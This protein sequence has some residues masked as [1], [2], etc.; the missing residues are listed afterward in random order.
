M[1]YLHM[2]RGSRVTK[3]LY[4]SR[5]QGKITPG[6]LDDTAREAYSCGL[7]AY[8]ALAFNK[9]LDAP[10][11]A[12]VHSDQDPDGEYRPEDIPEHFGVEIDGEIVDI[13]GAQSFEFW[14][15]ANDGYAVHITA[16][17]VRAWQRNHENNKWSRSK[18]WE[19]NLL[20]AETFVPALMAGLE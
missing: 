8:L 19:E 18:S 4:V 10:I 13:N 6:R 11:W 3:D 7:C 2:G 20:L 12:I 1:Y 16:E 14:E 17:E 15:A 9:K 5:S